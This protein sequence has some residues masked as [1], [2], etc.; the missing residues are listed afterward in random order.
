M[1][2]NF[3]KEKLPRFY[4]LGLFIKRNL[5]YRDFLIKERKTLRFYSQFIKKD[6]LCFD[7]GANIGN[8]TKLFLKLGGRVVAIEPQ[9]LA[10]REIQKLYGNSKNLTVVNEGLASKPGNLELSIC[11]DCDVISTM[12]DRWQK[13]S[14]FSEDYKWNKKQLVPVSTLDNFIERYGTPRFCKV[15]V[16]GFENNVLK[17]LSYPIPLISVRFEKEF[18]GEMKEWVQHLISLGPCEANCV[19]AESGDWLF[20]KWMPLEEIVKELEK[21][22]DENLWGDIFVRF[23]ETEKK[24]KLHLGCGGNI[25]PGYINIDNG[26]RKGVKYD[27]R[28]DILDLKFGDNSVD[29]IKMHHVFEH[30]HRYQAVALM[31]AFNNWLKSGGRLII[32]TPD[33]ELCCQEY[34]NFMTPLMFSRKVLHSIKYKKNYFKPDK[35]QILRHIFGSKEASWA[36]HMEGWDKFTL[37]YIY[38]LLGFKII[39]TEQRGIKGGMLP[40]IVITGEKKKHISNN[41]FEGLAREFLQ[42]M[43]VNDFEL[44]ILLDGAMKLKEVF[45]NN[46]IIKDLDS[47]I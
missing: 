34:L 33:F 10:C 46:K 19:L 13:E 21:N 28:A 31:F 18:F 4:L 5:F 39:K 42:K 36:N 43:I 40:N 24:I 7:V 32:E 16:E 37:F 17:G 11:E 20:E 47:Q 29:E 23:S 2:F 30:F 38:E 44:P 9:K 8:K 3:L 26:Q 45:L 15:I 35:W 1:S 25:L 22:G 27:I 6:D 14:R 12:S 41:E